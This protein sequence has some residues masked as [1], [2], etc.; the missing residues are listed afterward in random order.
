MRRAGRR[1]WG[2]IAHDLGTPLSRLAFW[3]EQLPDESRTRAV[4]DIDEMRAMIAGALRF[5]RDEGG[6]QQAVRRRSG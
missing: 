6:E 1:C 5:A 4:A 3:V 2:A